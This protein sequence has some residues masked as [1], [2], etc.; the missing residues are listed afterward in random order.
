M[1]LPFL[2]NFHRI[3]DLWME[4]TWPE[5]CIHSWQSGGDV[6][7]WALAGDRQSDAVWW[8]RGPGWQRSILCV[9]REGFGVLGLGAASAE[10]QDT[11]G[12]WDHVNVGLPCQLHWG[13]TGRLLNKGTTHLSKWAASLHPHTLR[14][15]KGDCPGGAVDLFPSAT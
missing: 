3:R 7:L 4:W 1:E 14:G 10:Q 11:H 6:T 5:R 13:P 9:C 8:Q 15:K 2:W 12:R